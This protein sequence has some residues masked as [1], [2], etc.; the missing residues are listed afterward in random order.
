MQSLS[1]QN[2]SACQGDCGQVRTTDRSG[3]G[4]AVL[5]QGGA[6]ISLTNSGDGCLVSGEMKE[7]VCLIVFD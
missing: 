6:V 5:R 4:P 3:Q 7:T 1:H 2:Q